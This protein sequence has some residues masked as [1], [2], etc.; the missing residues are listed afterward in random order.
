MEAVE[1]LE[2]TEGVK[3]VEIIEAAKV[4][5]PGKSLLMT[6]ELADDRQLNRGINH[7]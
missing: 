2:A 5:R 6:A 7:G 3:S 1:V 4:L